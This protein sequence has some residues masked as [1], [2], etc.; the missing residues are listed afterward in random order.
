MP[1]ATRGVLDFTKE[2]VDRLD[3]ALKR[4]LE[5]RGNRGYQDFSPG[6]ELYTP[7]LSFVFLRMQ[8]RLEKLTWAVAF[9][10]IV[11][12]ALACLQLILAAH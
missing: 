3:E 5:L 11:L 2:D 12:V 7:I 6:P 4:F 8:D 10:T 9:F 1:V